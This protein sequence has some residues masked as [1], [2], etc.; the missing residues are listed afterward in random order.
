[1]WIE[2]NIK[3]RTLLFTA[4]CDELEMTLI[5]N[6]IQQQCGTMQYH[7]EWTTLQ[8]HALALI[9]RF[10]SGIQT[11]MPEIQT[12]MLSLSVMG[13]YPYAIS[14]EL[15]RRTVCKRRQVKT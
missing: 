6:H 13:Y 8:I 15:N 3:S 1:M 7:C 9:H 4:L 12:I 10:H 2:T 11:I 14:A 5:S